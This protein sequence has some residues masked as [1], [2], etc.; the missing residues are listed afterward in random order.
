MFGTGTF[1]N[2]RVCSPD[3]DGRSKYHKLKTVKL[4]CCV[5][6]RHVNVAV[7]HQL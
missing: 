1:N 4:V 6:K 7:G 3:D 5:R 2:G